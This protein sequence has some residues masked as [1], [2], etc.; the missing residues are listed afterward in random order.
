MKKNLK[1]KFEKKV[2]PKTFSE[3]FF[4]NFEQKITPQTPP[5]KKKKYLKKK[6][7]PLGHPQGN[8]LLVIGVQGIDM[9]AVDGHGLNE[10]GF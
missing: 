1:K 6:I 9:V 7:G 2:S 10:G 8:F 3:I 5:P 4:F